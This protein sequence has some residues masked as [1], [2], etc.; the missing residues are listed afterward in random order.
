MTRYRVQNISQRCSR[1]HVNR[2]VIKFPA[3]INVFLWYIGNCM[4]AKREVAKKRNK[5]NCLRSVLRQTGSRTSGKKTGSG[6]EL[7]QKSDPDAFHPWA[8]RLIF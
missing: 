2:Y 7:L 5:K 4:Q 8:I 6:S 1:V 3:E